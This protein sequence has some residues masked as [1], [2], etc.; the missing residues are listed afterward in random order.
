MGLNGKIA[1]FFKIFWPLPLPDP[2]LLPDNILSIRSVA[3]RPVAGPMR[4][5]NVIEI[6]L[7]I[8][9]FVDRQDVVWFPR[10]I[11]A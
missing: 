9:T 8:R 4:S 11:R 1:H 3:S 10:H 7:K 5:F 6:E 2:G